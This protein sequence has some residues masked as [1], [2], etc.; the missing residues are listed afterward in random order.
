MDS[1]TKSCNRHLFSFHISQVIRIHFFF[2]TSKVIHAASILASEFEPLASSFIKC[3]QQTFFTLPSGVFYFL[4]VSIWQE[5]FYNSTFNNLI[6]IK[7]SLFQEIKGIIFRL[8]I[9]ISSY[10]STPNISHTF[11]QKKPLAL[12]YFSS[13]TYPSQWNTRRPKAFCLWDFVRQLYLSY[14]RDIRGFIFQITFDSLASFIHW[15]DVFRRNRVLVKQNFRVW[16][17]AK[18]RNLNR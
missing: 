18:V 14:Q 8:L 5:I 11:P 10:K 13:S 2:A 6:Y 16:I 9:L 3:Y 15:Q 17:C 7:V 1:E 12:W 4:F